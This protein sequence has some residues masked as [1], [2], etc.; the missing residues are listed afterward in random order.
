MKSFINTAVLALCLFITNA[1]ADVT[2][3]NTEQCWNLRNVMSNFRFHFTHPISFCQFYLSNPRTTT[4]VSVFPAP[5]LTDACACYLVQQSADIPSYSDK[6]GPETT[7]QCNQ[8]YFGTIAS[9]FA[10]QTA[11]CEFMAFI[12]QAH[13]PVRSLTAGEV[14]QGCACLREGNNGWKLSITDHPD[15]ILDTPAAIGNIMTAPPATTLVTV[16]SSAAAA[17]TNS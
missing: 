15:M 1:V 7:P 5:L 10:N 4:P 2:V 3:P 12:P 9:E 17:A 16:T 8:Q 11:L 6:F 14:T 13:S